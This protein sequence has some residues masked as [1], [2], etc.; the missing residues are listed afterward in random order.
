MTANSIMIGVATSRN[1][2]PR[3]ERRP[4]S[5]EARDHAR[6]AIP[7]R[8]RPAGHIMQGDCIERIGRDY[9]GIELDTMYHRTA[10]ARLHR[11]N[12]E[13]HV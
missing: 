9:I 8:Q 12:A 7:P 2:S 10:S 5:A 4:P 6:T 1:R 3:G 13:R 11:R